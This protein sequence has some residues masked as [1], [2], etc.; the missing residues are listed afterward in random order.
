M[1]STPTVAIISPRKRLMNAL[2]IDP[3]PNAT[4]LVSPNR[5]IAKY[6]GESNLSANVANGC[7][8]ATA[9][10][11]DIQAA[12][13]RCEERPAEGFRRIAL[14]RHRIAVPKQ[15]HVQRLPGYAEQNRRE[16]AA[17]CPRDVHRG[18]QDDRRRDR[19]AV[20]E[21]QREHDAHHERKARQHG[22]EHPDD[23]ADDE[24]DQVRRLQ[25]G[26]EAA[27]E[28]LENFEHRAFAI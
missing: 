8:I 23:Q 5:M 14:V 18:E 1:P 16:R 28:I 17:I 13:E 25:D 27:A 24:G 3:P 7:T 12:G 9:T 6:S 4:M 10:A 2:M 19:H 26:Y 11:V 15:R 20:R 21:R 22:D